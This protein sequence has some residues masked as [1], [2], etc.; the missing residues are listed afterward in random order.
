VF[1]GPRISVEA[2][3]ASA[4]I[5]DLFPA[6]AL[7]GRHYWDGLFASNPPV[8]ELTD[9]PIDELW[10]IQI[11]PSHCEH[12]PVTVDDIHD[13]RDELAG[14]LSLEREL[15]FIEKVNELL[16][17]G[18]LTDGRYLPI[19]VRRIALGRDLDHAAKLDRSESLIQ[20]LIAQGRERA[21]EF[22]G[23][24]VDGLA[25]RPSGGAGNRRPTAR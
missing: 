13:R 25:P 22:L 9:R 4:A 17:R 8:R 16:R 5:P 6:V 15:R 10:V 12:L 21:R 18:V 2:V 23:H 14:N 1:R 7:D 3:L 24:R 20:G 19:V 11:N